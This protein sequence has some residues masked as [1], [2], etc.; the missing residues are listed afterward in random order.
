MAAKTVLITGS[1][2]GFGLAFVQHYKQLGWKVIG[3]ARSLDAAD[4]VHDD[5]SVVVKSVQN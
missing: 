2:R 5:R 4:Q 3:A 1:T